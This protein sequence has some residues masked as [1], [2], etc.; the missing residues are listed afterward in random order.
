MY[1]YINKRVNLCIESEHDQVDIEQHFHV[2]SYL[3][4]TLNLHGQQV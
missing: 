4:V 1:S 3:T 2:N